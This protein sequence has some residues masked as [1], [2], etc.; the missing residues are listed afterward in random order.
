MFA[1]MLFGSAQGGDLRYALKAGISDTVL[2]LDVDG[3]KFVFLDPRNYGIFLSGREERGVEPVLIGKEMRKTAQEEFPEAPKGLAVALKII[4]EYA[5]SADEIG[6]SAVLPIVCADFL[7]QNGIK[8][9][10][11]DPFF[12]ERAVKN[13]KEIEAVKKVQKALEKTFAKLESILRSSSVEDG[14]LYY[15][16]S[17]LTSEF[18]KAEAGKFLLEHGI[19][20]QLGMIISSGEDTATPHNTGS[21]AIRHNSAVIIDIFPRDLKSGYFSDMTRSFFVGD[22]SVEWKKM[23]SAVLAAQTAAINEIRPRVRTGKIH[24]ICTDVFSKLDFISDDTQGFMHSAGHGVGLDIHEL[25]SLSP[26]NEYEL[27]PGNILTV[28][29]GLYYPGIGGVRIEDIVLVTEDGCENLTNYHKDG[30]IG[31]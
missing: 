10:I 29:P 31:L 22:A 16:G 12:P 4:R 17:A 7:R 24:E 15:A 27:L 30:I 8:L 23:H 26:Q 20:D 25:P 13:L 1:K 19:S 11:I 9:K 18:L 21:G 3:K 28:E 5:P 14:L 2:Y 6:V